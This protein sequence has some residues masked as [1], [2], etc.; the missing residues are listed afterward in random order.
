METRRRSARLMKNSPGVVDDVSLSDDDN[1][2]PSEIRFS[3]DSLNRSN[4]YY[5]A[6]QL[7]EEISGDSPDE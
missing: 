6:Q 1:A 2:G 7:L 3:Q 5:E 4:P